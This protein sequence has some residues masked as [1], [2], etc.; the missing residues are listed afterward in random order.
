MTW[1]GREQ[2][3]L[4]DNHQYHRVPCHVD[5]VRDREKDKT[6]KREKEIIERERKKKREIEKERKR[7]KEKE[8]RIE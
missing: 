2:T 4:L 8:R 5:T 7:E 1:S 3:R 6:V